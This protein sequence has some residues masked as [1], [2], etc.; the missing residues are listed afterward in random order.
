[1]EALNAIYGLRSDLV[2]FLRNMRSDYVHLREQ[3]RCNTET[4]GRLLQQS[5]EPPT[6]FMDSHLNLMH[7]P[8]MYH[9][10]Q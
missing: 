5:Q 10:I 1:M 8:P 2:L 3:I 6:C 9:S 4:L 7:P